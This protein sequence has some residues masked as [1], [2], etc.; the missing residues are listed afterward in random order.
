VD[1]ERYLLTCMRYI[2]LNPVRAGIVAQASD[3]RWSSYRA[4]ALGA[5]D[6]VVQR[7]ELYDRLGRSEV[8]RLE[9]YRSLFSIQPPESE[10]EAIR[11]ATNKNWALGSDG[12]KQRV[13]TLSGR[14][15]DRMR[16]GRPTAPR[17]RESRV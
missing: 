15:P 14:R 12:F 4:N 10:L 1:S 17:R 5:S 2:E 9:A 6:A 7:H 8:E 3:Y 11:E 13:A 16:M